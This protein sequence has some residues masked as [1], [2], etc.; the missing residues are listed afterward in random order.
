MVPE[1]GGTLKPGHEGRRPAW[2]PPRRLEAR[3]AGDPRPVGASLPE[4]ARLLGV[5]AALEVALVRR[6]WVALVGEALAGHTWP[7]RLQGGVLAVCADD[8]AWAAEL[9]FHAAT[10]VAR[11]RGLVPGIER[12]SVGVGPRNEQI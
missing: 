3:T 8:G 12:L 7:V 2:G 5:A 6:N 10:V 4:A 11:S 1:D 9:R